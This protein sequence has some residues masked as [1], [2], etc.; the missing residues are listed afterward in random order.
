MADTKFEPWGICVFSESRE[1]S[2]MQQDKYCLVAAAGSRHL[3]LIGHVH[4]RFDGLIG[5]VKKLTNLMLAG[6]VQKTGCCQQA[7][8]LRARGKGDTV[9][10]QRYTGW[11][12]NVNGGRPL[13]SNWP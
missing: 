1:L 2:V 5:L 3:V 4:Y 11:R 9:D 13:M 7:K 10:R 12:C 8:C 6:P